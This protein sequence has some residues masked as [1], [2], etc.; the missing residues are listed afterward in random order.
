MGYF[1]T[2]SGGKIKSVGIDKKYCFTTNFSREFNGFLLRKHMAKCYIRLELGTPLPY[3]SFPP[4]PTEMTYVQLE[5][6]KVS[7]KP[8]IY[9]MPFSTRKLEHHGT[10]LVIN[11]GL[12]HHESIILYQIARSIIVE[13][14]RFIFCTRIKGMGIL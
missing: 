6:W 7:H 8:D 3:L 4:H 5:S 10:R 9:V 13:I 12:S 14:G 2:Y 1:Y 11:G